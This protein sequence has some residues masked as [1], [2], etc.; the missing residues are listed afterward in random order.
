MK[1]SLEKFGYVVFGLLVAFVT[2][3][4][5]ASEPKV[6]LLL[7]NFTRDAILVA[8]LVVAA[9]VVGESLRKWLGEKSEGI[10][11]ALT[12]IG[13][14]ISAY[15]AAIFFIGILG[16]LY[17]AVLLALVALGLFIGIRRFSKL[18]KDLKAYLEKDIRTDL[19]PVEVILVLMMLLAGLTAFLAVLVPEIFYDS[20]YYH[21]ALG[22]MYLIRH[23]V[24]IFPFAVHSAM[25][26]YIDFL[27]VPLL[28]F[29]DSGTVKLCHF[30]LG[31]GT[32]MWIYVIGDRWFGGS[33]GLCGA[34]LFASLPGVGTMAGLGTVD[35]GVSFFALGSF[36]LL[37]RWIFEGEGRGTL[38]ASAVLLGAAV[39]SKYSAL[40]VGVVAAVGVVVGAIKRKGIAKTALA[41]VMLFGAVSLAV[42]SPWYLRNL[43]VFHNP[44]YPALEPAGSAGHFAYLNLKHDSAKL[45]SWVATFWKLP[46]DVALGKG[47]FG[48]G[49]NISPGILLI[50]AGFVWGF[51]RKGFPRWASVGILLLYVLWARSVLVVR[52]FYP[53]LALATV[54]CGG[55]LMREGRRRATAAAAVIAVVVISL[56]GLRG[57][58]LFQESYYKGVLRYLSTSM[59]PEKYLAHF[60]PHSAPAKW[61]SEN[62]PYRGTKLLM[63]GETR[64][65]YFDRDYEPISA[66]DKHPLVAWIKEAKSAGK[67]RNLLLKKGFTHV[68]WRPSE[69]ERL[70]KSYRHCKL[71]KEEKLIFDE[72]LSK[73]RL[74][75][76]GMG[77]EVYVL[78]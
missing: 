39:G 72:L 32:C 13:L 28:A 41:D 40:A 37:A 51:F 14:G 3:W 23:R 42:A 59:A 70:N 78:E 74:I 57:M 24:E 21:D 22:A 38:L 33:A 54:L 9:W 16:L 12:A 15:A 67:L 47:A 56:I 35:L 8:L 55:M 68:I 30:A 10:E 76:K 65:Y 5:V 69:L 77:M 26:S 6:R 61:I 46:K 25:P 49:A 63:V 73:S 64:G 43:I 34:V 53:G 29:G 45:Y 18:F 48:A 7:G 66:Y 62:T 71:S 31:V 44:I 75:L 27:Y 60:A 1:K 50:S 4:A 2:V 52:Y 20:L 11:G 58:V 17:P 19:S 36:A